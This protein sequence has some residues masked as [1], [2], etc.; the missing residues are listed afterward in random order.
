MAL[1][2]CIGLRASTV[3]GKVSELVKVASKVAGEVAG[4]VAGTAYRRPLELLL[5][6]QLVV[7]VTTELSALVLNLPAK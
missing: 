7:A 3:G 5:V 4:E 1:R 6:A 2:G